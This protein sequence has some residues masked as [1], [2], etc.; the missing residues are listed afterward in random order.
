MRLDHISEGVY[1]IGGF[2]SGVLGANVY[3][4]VDNGI[5]LVDTGFAGRTGDIVKAAAQFS[6]APSDIRNIIITHHHPDHTGNLAQLKRLSG[7]EVIAHRED[8]PYID[9]RLAQPLTRGARIL[10]RLLKPLIRLEPCAVDRCVE[11]G[12][13]LDV[14]G[15]GE[16]V[17]T[18]GHT[19]GSISLHFP[20]RGLLIVGDVIAHRFKLDL[21]ARTYTVNMAEEIKSIKK[22][23]AM[24]FQVICFGHGRPILQD[25]RR[26]IAGYAASL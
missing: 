6:F 5:M 21:P 8:A 12:D 2:G 18:P 3:L 24:D 26:T 7:A 4:L 19:P 13:I 23:A 15:G 14:L 1:L 10:G 25:A 17:H 11:G 9:G 22:L 20:E 16:I